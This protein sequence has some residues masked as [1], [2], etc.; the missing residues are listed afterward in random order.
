LALESPLGRG[1]SRKWGLPPTGEAGP[2]GDFELDTGVFGG[3]WRRETLLAYGGW[4]ERWDK[5]EDSEL[6]ARFLR[7]GER[8]IC[9]PGMTPDYVPRDTLGGLWRQYE[10]YGRFRARTARRHPRSMRR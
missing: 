5:N 6:A 2:P 3:V 9:P 4:D 8:L 7:R 1:G 10:H